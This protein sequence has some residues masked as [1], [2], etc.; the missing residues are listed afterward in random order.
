MEAYSKYSKW[1]RILPQFSAGIKEGLQ[2][3]QPPRA[4]PLPHCEHSS[5]VTLAVNER[6]CRAVKGSGS[7]S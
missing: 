6:R 7:Q 1:E 4:C 5:E 2:E 3:L